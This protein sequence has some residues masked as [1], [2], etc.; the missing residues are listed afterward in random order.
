MTN[1]VFFLLFVINLTKEGMINY[2]TIIRKDTKVI[3]HDGNIGYG[4]MDAVLQPKPKIHLYN[5]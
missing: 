5:F 3:E 1:G 4:D 2:F